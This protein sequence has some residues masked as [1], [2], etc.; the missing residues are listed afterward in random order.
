VFWPPSTLHILGLA[1]FLR[2]YL[3]WAAVALPAD[4]GL[5]KAGPH[6]PV[7]NASSGR[8][9]ALA[10]PADPVSDQLYTNWTKLGLIVNNTLAG[11]L[12]PAGSDP[13]SA[14]QTPSKEWQLVTADGMITGSMDFRHWYQI[15][16]QPN[17][18][19][20]ADPSFFPLPR[21]TPGSSVASVDAPP[22]NFVYK[23]SVAPPGKPFADWMQVGMFSPGA[24][25]QNST[26]IPAGPH[27]LVDGGGNYQTSKDFFDDRT[28]RRILWGNVG[29]PPNGALS[30][31]REV[32]WHP[33]LR[34]LVYTPVQELA[35]LR[36]AVLGSQRALELRPGTPVPLLDAGAKPGAGSQVIYMSCS[37]VAMLICLP[38]LLHVFVLSE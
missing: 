17:F 16:T 30:L 5:W 23:S 26:W 36:G 2:P 28:G 19:Q 24:P 27:T 12:G 22:Y 38:F 3:T 11:P 18:T 8:D 10:T 37:L 31:P 35:L 13:S 21:Q 29:A 4:P 25:R 7:V 32:T 1:A 9:L 14:W 33:A 15:G 6:Q 20:S 34:Q